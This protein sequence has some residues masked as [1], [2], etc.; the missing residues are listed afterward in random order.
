M[1]PSFPPLLKKLPTPWCLTFAPFPPSPT[2]PFPIRHGSSLSSYQASSLDES[3]HAWPD[4][5]ASGVGIKAHPVP[6]AWTCCLKISPFGREGSGTGSTFP[7]LHYF[8][9]HQ[10]LFLQVSTIILIISKETA[11]FPETGK[12][13]P[14]A[15]VWEGGSNHEDKH[16][17]DKSLRL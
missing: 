14:S 12:P 1:A 6:S 13:M 16:V 17:T 15:I 3:Y 8:M 2:C 5:P 11:L 10:A 9:Y 4:N 7:R